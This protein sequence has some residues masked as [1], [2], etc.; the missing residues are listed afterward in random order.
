MPPPP[1]Q[2]LTT[3]RPRAGSKRR[4]QDICAVQSQ[5]TQRCKFSN[6]F[7]VILNEEKEEIPM[8][9]SGTQEK[10]KATTQDTC[11]DTKEPARSDS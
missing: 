3:L 9:Q 8:S 2:R 7:D 4:L 1:L 11:C 6:N 10:G 5:S